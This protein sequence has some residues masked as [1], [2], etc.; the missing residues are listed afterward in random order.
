MAQRIATRNGKAQKVPA[1]ANNWTR[2]MEQAFLNELAATANVRASLKTIERTHASLYQRRRN[3]PSFRQEWDEALA[4]GYARLEAELLDEALNGVPTVLLAPGAEPVE[5]V[6]RRRAPDRLRLNLL[7]QHGKRVAEFRASNAG[8]ADES[9]DL[10]R[11]ITQ[12]LKRLGE[13]LRANEGAGSA[14]VTGSGEGA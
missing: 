12:R 11:M 6:E 8:K 4:E 13:W 2:E 5:P 9:E 14:S 1:K 3:K 7:A 10:R